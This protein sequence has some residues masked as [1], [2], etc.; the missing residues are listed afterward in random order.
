MPQRTVYHVAPSDQGWTLQR[1]GD[2]HSWKFYAT[3]YQAVQ[4]AEREA[5]A[6]AASEL[7]IHNDDGRVEEARRFETRITEPSP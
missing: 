5:A 1:E 6:H 4:E 3:K 2:M 7:I